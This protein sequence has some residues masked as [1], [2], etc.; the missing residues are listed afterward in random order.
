MKTTTLQELYNF[1]KNHKDTHRGCGGEPYK[2]YQ[3]LFDIVKN[4]AQDKEAV[5]ILELGTAIGFTAIV[6]RSANANIF[7]D[8]IDTHTEHI[9]IAK[10]WSREYGGI[11]VIQADVFKILPYLETDKYDIVFYDVYG[12]KYKFLADL[13]RVLKKGGLLIT[14]NS[15]LKSTEE[16]YFQELKGKNQWVFLEEFEDTIVYRKE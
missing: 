16:E 5:E 4:Y 8:T 11:N 9:K 12:A 10:S 15:H 13:D 14:A 7:V 3:R 6:M 2:S 1:A